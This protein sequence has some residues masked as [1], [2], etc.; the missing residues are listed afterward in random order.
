MSHDSHRWRR[1]HHREELLFCPLSPFS[2]SHSL[3]HLT[4]REK[5]SPQPASYDHT[6][7][8]CFLFFLPFLPGCC[9][10]QRFRDSQLFIRGYYGSK[11]V[12]PLR[13]CTFCGDH[14]YFAILDSE[15]NADRAV[16][17]VLGS[18]HMSSSFVGAPCRHVPR[19]TCP[20]LRPREEGRNRKEGTQQHNRLIAF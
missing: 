9:P 7:C 14:G 5:V 8:C 11:T 3:Y 1:R 18:N 15:S 4:V 16:P 2:L 17:C 20:M 6:S 19:S 12:L 13:H 10:M